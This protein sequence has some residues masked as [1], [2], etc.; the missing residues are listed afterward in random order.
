MNMLTL[1]KGDDTHYFKNMEMIE[2]EFENQINKKEVTDDRKYYLYLLAGRELLN[3]RYLD[4]SEKYYKKALALNLPLNHSEVYINLILISLKK[5]DRDKVKDRIIIANEYFK[6]NKKFLSS[7]LEEY[8]SFLESRY[9]SKSKNSA[10]DRV[11][12]RFSGHHIMLEE[13]IKKIK[14]KEYLDAY[15]DF[16]RNGLK[17]ADIGLKITYD[18]LNVLVHKKKVKHL[19]CTPLFERFPNSYSYSMKI[20][21]ILMMYMSTNKISQELISDL[22]KYFQEGHKD[23]I[24]LLSA[25]KDIEQ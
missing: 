13:I 19:L 3:Y 25:V 16:N 8:L 24:Y 18:I 7:E 1:V 15:S 9:F 17:G 2:H 21:K 6:K 10:L 11:D 5:N 12:K 20:C 23:K 14:N 22:E 4:Y